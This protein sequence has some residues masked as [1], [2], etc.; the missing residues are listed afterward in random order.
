MQ[1]DFFGAADCVTGSRHLVTWG[2]QRVLLD[3]GLF[4]GFKVLRER[5]WAPPPFEPRSLD[6]V[7]LSHAHLDHSGYVPVLV[8]RGFRGPVYCS[9]ATRDLAQVLWLDAAHLQE[10]DARRANR[11]GYSRHEKALPLFTRADVKKA[12]AHIRVLPDG[13]A[14]RIDG[15]SAT[16]TP[17]GHL[18][19]ACAVTLSLGG[20]KLVFSGDLGRSQDL[21]MPAPKPIAEADVLLVESTYGNRQHPAEDAAAR[22]GQ[23][24]RAHV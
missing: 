17:V 13:K 5:N 19:G 11:Y 8:Q 4:Q 9:P 15:L 2:G 16:L 23:I 18:L 1:I 7:V 6:A 20:E 24:G 3:S 22:L 12:L 21:L 10:E 14:A